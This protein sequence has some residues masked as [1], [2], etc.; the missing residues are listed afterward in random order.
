MSIL[1]NRDTRVI[2]QG[3]TGR[4]GS[5]HAERMIEY[6]TA[7]VGGVTPGK[8]G[9]EV[10][11]V[12]V[13]DSVREAFEATGADA[14]VIYVPAPAAADSIIEASDAGIRIVVCITEGIPVLD[15][16]RVKHRIAENGT[17]LIGPNC[18]GIITPDECKIGIMPGYIHRKGHVGVISRSGTLTYEAVK[19]LSDK[20]I[21]QSTVVGIGGD[22]IRGLGFTDVLRLFEEDD[23]THA[24]VINGE[25]GGIG[26]EE[27]AQYI[28]E[29]M[30][31]PV[32]AFI[33]GR[34]AP[35]G[36]RMGHAGAI[37][38]GGRGT[39]ESKIA[40]LESAG[41]V[42]AETADRIGDALIEAAARSGA[43]LH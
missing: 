28:R 21:G 6:G 3:I 2:V 13:F 19:Q 7:I 11:G 20:G 29:C 10:L 37:V 24:V 15:M 38:N 39:A 31:K 12:P 1:V 9:M 42:I 25:I 18:P 14:S 35:K 27:A 17:I 30:H 33:G 22:P 34:S 26:E 5:F 41:V 4:Q 43:V 16:A 8:G 36:K 32:A 23:D 40:A